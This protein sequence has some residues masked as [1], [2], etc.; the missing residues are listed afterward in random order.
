MQAKQAADYWRT[1]NGQPIPF[2]GDVGA[3]TP[4]GGHPALTAKLAPEAGDRIHERMAREL[5]DE[6]HGQKPDMRKMENAVSAVLANPSLGP[7]TRSDLMDRFGLDAEL[8]NKVIE[9]VKVYRKSQPQKG[10]RFS[11]TRADAILR[12]RDSTGRAKARR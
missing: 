2:V 1:V 4:V 12:T 11:D 9:A 8:A 7:K 10:Q 5:L 6:H 3:G